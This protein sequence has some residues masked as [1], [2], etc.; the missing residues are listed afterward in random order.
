MYDIC[1][2]LTKLHF[3]CIRTVHCPELICM[4]GVKSFSSKIFLCIQLEVY[5]LVMQ[6]IEDQKDQK[7]IKKIMC[8]CSA[9][10]SCYSQI[11]KKTILIR[12]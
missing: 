7:K 2:Y 4:Y 1:L 10:S 11:L 12:Q 9:N 8:I 5:F 6:L 3:F